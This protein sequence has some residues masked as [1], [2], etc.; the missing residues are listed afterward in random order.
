MIL[1]GDDILP[2][3]RGISK[4]VSVMQRKILALDK[5]QN[6]LNDPEVEFDVAILEWL[7]GDYIAGYLLP[8]EEN[9][10]QR[11]VAPLVAKKRNIVLSYKDLCYNASLVLGNS[12]ISIGKSIQLPGTYKAVGGFHVKKEREPLTK[13]LKTLM[14][15]SKNGVIYFSMGSILKSKD[16]PDEIVLGILK[17]LSE[18][19]QT[20]LWKFE[21]DLVNT[22]SNVHFISWAPQQSILAHPNCVLFISHGGLLSA[23]EAVHFGV[24]FIGIP[25]FADQIA[26]VKTMARKGMAKEVK[27]S[28]NVASD[29]KAAIKEVLGNS[30]YIQAAKHQSF[31][32]HHR[33]VS[34]GA[35]LVHWVEHVIQSRGAS[36]LRSISLMVPWYQRCHLDVA[37]VAV[38]LIVLLIKMMKLILWTMRSIKIKSNKIKKLH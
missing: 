31:V 30:S 33:P 1:N 14:D 22:E 3:A 8:Q 5:V 21:T 19:E 32:Y 20:V 34:P 10:Y 24:P 27:L 18:L 15:N 37:I 23:L 13:D 16:F 6:L 35:E 17:V 11:Y 12:H 25:V 38:I 4:V 29:L 36:H 26:N 2:D 7:Y 28:Y 9:D